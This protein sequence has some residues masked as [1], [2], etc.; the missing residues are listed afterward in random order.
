[1]SE[2]IVTRCDFLV[3]EIV[4]GRFIIDGVLGEG[5]FGKVFRVKDGDGQI[6]AL[7]LLKLWEVPS[8]VR[9]PLVQRFSMEFQTGQIDS[10]Y[11]VRSLSYGSVKGNPYIIMEFCPGGDLTGFNDVSLYSKVGFEMLSGLKALHSCGKVHRDLKP[12]NVLFK[13]NGVAALTDF[14]ISGD[15]NKRMTER[16]IF[17]KPQQIFGT[18]AYMPPEQV[19]RVRGEATVLP[20]TDIFSFGVLFF[21]LLT[22]FL[23]FGKLENH[24][25]LVTYQMN[26]KK[27]LW[28]QHSLRNVPDGEKW[29]LLIEGCLEPDFK[30]RLQSAE[31]VLKLLPYYSTMSNIKSSR[32]SFDFFKK[33]DNDLINSLRIMQGEEFGQIY[34]LTEMYK[35]GYS[36]FTMG[37]E[38]DNLLVVKEEQSFYM[39]RYHCTIETDGIRWFIRD[40]Q[41]QPEKNSWI[42]STN[43]TF[44]NSTPVS[45]LGLMLNVGDIISIGDVKLR[46]ES[47]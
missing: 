36:L 1:M 13:S 9:S 43:G 33:K 24:N 38:E 34:K 12:E 35:S 15:R 47:N 31:D 7:K 44:V 20:T 6:L 4:D 28:A 40:G 42:N 32:K 5:S 37:R 26:A 2:A 46:V 21:Q 30:H 25:D 29:K 39:S 14:G 11:L 19:N 22:G 10:E 23:P 8:E 27:G 41:W 3:G 18:Y 17:G 16:N 45:Q